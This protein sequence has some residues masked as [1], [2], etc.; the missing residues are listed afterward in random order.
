MFDGS[1]EIRKSYDN[2]VIMTRYLFGKMLKLKGFSKTI[3]N[4]S[5]MSHL[6]EGNMSLSLLMHAIFGHLK[7]NG[8]CLLRKNGVYGLPTIL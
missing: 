8:L 4:F 7:Y 5:Y 6:E 3:Q 1:V 2:K